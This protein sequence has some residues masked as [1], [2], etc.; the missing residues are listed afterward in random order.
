MLLLAGASTCLVCEAQRGLIDEA[1]SY[2]EQHCIHNDVWVPGANIK[3]RTK[4]NQTNLGR[5]FTDLRV[6]RTSYNIKGSAF[7]EIN[8]FSVKE[9]QVKSDQEIDALFFRVQPKGGSA[10]KWFYYGTTEGYSHDHK[11][12]NYNTTVPEQGI[13][14]SYT[15]LWNAYK[16]E[17]GNDLDFQSEEYTITFRYIVHAYVDRECND[18][19]DFKLLTVDSDPVHLY[20]CTPGVI[21]ADETF[22]P[23]IEDMG[24]DIYAVYPVAPI[25]RRGNLSTGSSAVRIE[26]DERECPSIYTTDD[27]HLRWE[28]TAKDGSVIGSTDWRLTWQMRNTA[29]AIAPGFT[30]SDLSGSGTLDEGMEFNVV[31]KNYVVGVTDA[32]CETEPLKFLVV[33][34]AE[35]EGFDNN[36]MRYVCPL[37]DKEAENYIGANFNSEVDK[38]A[39]FVIEGNRLNVE[40]NLYAPVYCIKYKWQYKTST[41][42]S[43]ID[44][45]ETGN[46]SAVQYNRKDKYKNHFNTA[47]QDLIVPRALFQEGNIYEFRQVAVLQNFKDREIVAGENGIVRVGTYRKIAEDDFYF[48]KMGPFCADGK[49][50]EVGLNVGF[51]PTDTGAYNFANDDKGLSYTWNFKLAGVENESEIAT[52]LSKKYNVANAK[53]ATEK[54]TVKVADGCNNE[55]VLTQ[56]IGYEEQPK[57]DLNTIVCQKASKTVNTDQN[58]VEA[59]IPEG[60]PGTLYVSSEDANYALSDYLYSYEED[61]DYQ[62]M[63]RGIEVKLSSE[64]TKTIYIKKKSKNGSQCESDPVRVVF[65]KIGVIGGNKIV[66]D[67]LFVCKNEKNPQIIASPAT[68][69]YGNGTFAYKWIYSDDDVTYYPMT[70]GEAVIETQN[71]G[72]RKWNLEI[73]RPY[74]IRRIATSRLGDGMLCDTSAYVVVKP[75]STPKIRVVASNTAACYGEEVE[76]GIQQDEGSITEIAKM[77]LNVSYSFGSK[78]N[79]E[80]FQFGKPS[81][82]VEHTQKVSITRD[83]LVYATIDMCGTTITSSP[84]RI[85]SGEDLT[86]KIVEGACK[87]RGGKVEVAIANPGVGRT[88]SILQNGVELGTTTAGLQIPEVGDVPYKV[89]VS[90]AKCAKETDMRVDASRIHDRLKQLQLAISNLDEPV[91]SVCAGGK[92]YTIATL[93]SAVNRNA[94]DYLWYVNGKSVTD[95]KDAALNYTFPNVGA[96]YT[97]VRESREVQDGDVCQWVRDTVKA[98]TFDRVSAGE[99]ALSNSGYVCDGEEVTWTLGGMDGGSQTKYGYEVYSGTEKVKSGLVMKDDTETDEIMFKNVGINSVYAKVYDNE[100]TDQTLYSAETKKAT[101]VQAADMSFSLTA[102][103]SMVAES[104]KASTISITATAKNGD[105]EMDAFA[106]SYTTGGGKKVEDGKDGSPFLLVIDS[107]SFTNDRLVVNVVRTEAGSGCASTSQV[108]ITQSQGFED[109][110]T[111]TSNATGETVCGGEE[112]TFGIEE[113]P[114]FGTTKLTPADVSYSWYKDGS[115]IASS[116]TCKV[117]AVAGDTIGITCKIS[118]KY[119]E[120]LKPAYVYAKEVQLIGKSGVKIGNIKEQETASNMINICLGETERENLT[121]VVDDIEIGE[122]DVLEWQQSANG[123]TWTRVPTVNIDKGDEP[124]G[125]T[126][127]VLTEKYASEKGVCY[128]RLQGTSECGTA[129]YSK[130]IITLRVDTLPAA[131][132]VALR[133]SNVIRGAVASLNFSPKSA[134]NGFVYKWGTTEEDL[135]SVET[136]GG[137][138]A[139]LAGEYKSGM[140]KIYVRKVAKSGGRCASA[141][142]EYDFKLYDELTIGNLVPGTIDTTDK[143][144][145]NNGELELYVVNIKGGSGKYDIAWEYKSEGGSWIAFDAQTTGLPFSA[146]FAGGSFLDSYQYQL[147]LGKLSATTSFRATVSSTGDYAGESKTTNEFTVNYYE[148]LKDGGIDN[149]ELLLCYGAVLP[150]IE[151]RLPKGGDGEYTYQWLKTATPELENSWKEITSATRPNYTGRDTMMGTTYYKRVLTDG[152]GTTIE[153]KAKR[154]EVQTP[155]MITSEDVNYN[156]AVNDGKAANMW[157]VRRSATDESQFIW[158]DS[159]WIVLDTTEVSEIYTSK[160]LNAGEDQQTYTFYA[161]KIDAVSGCLSY[162]SDTLYVTAYTNT[163]GVIYVAGT[164]EENENS[165]WVCPDNTDVK[166]MSYKNPEGATYKWYYRVTTNAQSVEPTVGDWNALRQASGALVT[167]ENISMDTMGVASLFKNT[168][169]R[170]KYIELKRLAMFSISGENAEMESNIVRIN[171]VPT[172]PSVASLYDVVGTL[173]SDRTKYCKGEDAAFVSGEVDFASET[174]TIWNGYS[175]YFGPWLYEKEYEPAGFSTW[176]E[177]KLAGGEYDTADVR[178][179]NEDGYADIFMPGE[180]I[181]HAMNATYNVRRAVSDGCTS[182]YTNVLNLYVTDALGTMDRVQMYGFEEGSARK[183][184]KGFEIGDSLVVGYN[185]TD[186]AECMWALDSLFTNPLEE[187]KSYVGFRMTEDNAIRLMQDPHV[188]MKRLSNGCWSSTLAIPVALGTASDGGFIGGS[189]KVCKDSEFC[190]IASIVPATGDWIAPE[191]NAMKWTYSWQYSKDSTTWVDIAGSDSIVLTADLVNRYAALMSGNDSYFRRVARNDSARVR[192]SNGVRMSYYD[193]LKPGELTMNTSQNGL[194]FGEELPVVGTT[195]A[196]GGLTTENGVRYTWYVAVNSGDYVLQKPYVGSSIDLSFIDTVARADRSVNN[197]ISVRCAYSDGGCGVVES[198]PKEFVLFRKNDPPAI[199]QDNDS[200]DAQELTIKV[201]AE[202]EAKTYTFVAFSEEKPDSVVWSMETTQQTIRRVTNMVAENY[203]VYSVDDLTGCVSGYTYFNVDSLPTLTQQTLVAPEVVCYGAD[204]TVKGGEAVGGNG[205]KAYTWQYSYDGGEWADLANRFE[206]DLAVANPKTSTYYRRIARDMCAADT[207]APVF[208]TV[209]EKVVVSPADLVLHDY[210]CEGR[211]FNAELAEGIVNADN[212]YYRIWTYDGSEWTGSPYRSVTVEGFE[213]DSLKLMLSHIVVDTMGGKCEERIDIYA[214]NAVAIDHE[215]NVVSCADLTPC[216]GRL[217]DVVGESQ[218]ATDKGISYKWYVSSDKNK[219]TEQLLMTEKDL[220]VE[221]KDTMFIRRLVYNGCVYD[222]SNVVT[223]IGSKIEDY[224]YVTELGLSV[225][226]NMAD[227]TVALYVER[228]R[229]FSDGYYMEGDGQLPLVEGN[230]TT[231]PYGVETYKDSLLQIIAISDHCVKSYK[232]SPL[233]GG[234]ISFD[235]EGILCGGGVLPAIVATDVEGGLGSYTYQWQYKNIY[236]SD[237]INIDGA[238]KKEYTPSAVSVETEYRRI[239]FSGEYVSYSNVVS[240]NIRPLPKAKDIFAS[241]SDSALTSYGLAHN[242]YGTEKLPAI[243]MT[244]KDSISDV[245]EVVW[246]KSYDGATWEDVEKQEASATGLY[247]LYL[248]DTTE[249]VYYRSVGASACG[250]TTSKAFKVTTVYA[251]V[252]LEE[253]LVLTDNICAGEPYVRIRYKKDYT[254]VY[255]YTYRTIGYEGSGVFAWANTAVVNDMGEDYWQSRILS[256]LDDT[257]KTAMGAI[258]TY[259]KH[260]FDVEVTR[261][262]NATGASSTKLV[263]F[264]VNDLK[265]KFNYIVDGVELHQSGEPEQTVR[266]NQGSRVVFTPEV[267]G[268]NGTLSYKWNLIEP[269]NTAYY[270]TYGGSVGR[271]GLTSEREEP[272]CYFYNGGIYTIQMTVSD[273]QCQVSVRDSALYI[274]RNSVRSFRSGV[275]LEE[276]EMNTSETDLFVYV[277]V[278]P[279]FV[280]SYVS[281]RTNSPEPE[282]YT[283]YDANGRT[284]AEGDYCKT[285]TIDAQAWPTGVYVVKTRGKVVKVRKNGL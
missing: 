192:Y 162:N 94:T 84:L 171:V 17:S 283:V 168:T 68:G 285:E 270:T 280:T 7:K 49:T 52:E 183:I 73:D 226:T 21:R 92:G 24:E 124:I 83:T 194:C 220:R 268:G 135:N 70:S 109:V 208:V 236:T 269:L 204:F 251:P 235:G 69:G 227:S 35:L 138:Q 2:R 216:N 123:T 169:G 102:S 32:T 278:F 195:P 116:A 106:L 97:I 99:L 218:Q 144:C 229:E 224:D 15:D 196:T 149:G 34:A 22:T 40:D 28:A 170:A 230:L 212:D 19:C 248:T 38:D 16:N 98:R 276:A 85:T 258:F 39:F 31:R 64:T 37:G 263:H 200:C 75:Y 198:E 93:G 44:L 253:E 103:P 275:V 131:P 137:A 211:S 232:V 243:E 100:C 125:R 79:D 281:I 101:V 115:L 219:W 105:V 237:Y 190:M 147:I 42:S 96:S 184:Y 89:V 11:W 202:K 163:S 262:V 203:G 14:I 254:G 205:E 33:E 282:R 71:L 233:R 77:N 50:N 13:R 104:N 206:A 152:C 266:M 6:T 27:Q 249:T 95:A 260:S 62:S 182:A 23:K 201:V 222:T 25:N 119:D 113:L 172:M 59:S 134:Y 120:V 3:I 47:P 217:V 197:T 86:P 112:V 277:D 139:I 133:S 88:Y 41:S 160:G 256:R 165:F 265:A 159:R 43:W 191:Y 58:S 118:Y 274:D 175:K 128:F 122:K 153:S 241:I 136:E 72:A 284:V 127:T 140:N 246:Q 164:Q 161:K 76:L 210:K 228:G 185:A 121:L 261:I 146:K 176:F 5:G 167:A 1:V 221:V 132:V 54:V 108:I 48:D 78:K 178:R 81:E 154:V 231:L 150:N 18:G 130:N 91:A 60:V 207:T 259:P 238:N 26:S 30:Y 80:Y 55:V 244:L 87:V 57:V 74:Y 142:A 264:T 63:N 29:C 9:C 67:E 273:G 8:W 45:G 36:A 107:T 186:G 126:L 271:E 250:E 189:Q 82:Y 252:I 90:D 174:R 66:A 148:P 199:F 193:M 177:Y 51:K 267:E 56:E 157:G 180:G 255:S 53:A 242:Q 158:Y 4:V 181:S 179:Y 12:Q 166:I 111:I 10:S 213:G 279:T 188:Y 245:D 234:V 151:G 257:T 187:S 110:P 215:K 145:P 240:V 117:K 214:H 239:T 143:R 155:V 223:I 272:A 65:T 129:T 209:R 46:G 247:E 225:T 173:T 114:T 141:V 156:K 61:G 20:I